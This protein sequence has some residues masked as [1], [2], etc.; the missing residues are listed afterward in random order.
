MKRNWCEVT[1]RNKI[2][3]IFRIVASAC[4]VVLSILQL[5]DVWEQAIHLT[6]PLMGSVLL[7]QSI[8]EWKQQRGIAILELC[9][10]VFIFGCALVIWFV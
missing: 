10:A 3:L 9:C 7:V 8:Q 1:L 2:M 6:M 5:T 4:V